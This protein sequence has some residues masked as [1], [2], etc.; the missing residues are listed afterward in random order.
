MK[1][2][3]RMIS[4]VAVIAMALLA[5]AGLSAKSDEKPSMKFTETIHD[6]GNIR[7][8]GGPV[9]CD[10]SFTN[11]GKGNLV[12]IDATAE[13]GCTRPSYPKEPVA[14]GKSGKITVVYNPL[15]RPGAFNK[16]V[17]IKCNGKPSKVRLKIRGTV[18]PK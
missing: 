5:V 17:T 6:F 18:I 2:K 10:F 12:V 14:P 11:D 4:C 7:E 13:C 16:T 8:D 9:S 3:M 1:I 15:G